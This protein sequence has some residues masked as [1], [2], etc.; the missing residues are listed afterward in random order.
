MTAAPRPV[1][2]LCL[3]RFTTAV[4]LDV[5]TDGMTWPHLW[6]LVEHHRTNYGLTVDDA[7]E[8]VEHL[9]EQDAADQYRE[10]HRTTTPQ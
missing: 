2:P 7:A 8:V 5:H 3:D 1:D 10:H 6:Q 9:L 4:E